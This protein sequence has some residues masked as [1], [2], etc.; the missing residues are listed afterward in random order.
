M[1]WFWGRDNWSGRPKT[2]SGS[3]Y[4]SLPN[5]PITVHE[6][7]RGAIEANSISEYLVD[8]ATAMPQVNLLY[9]QESLAMD[10][11]HIDSIYSTYSLLH[12]L[13]VPIGFV[14]TALPIDT[15]VPLLIAGSSY[16]PEVAQLALREAVREGAKIFSAGNRTL[17]F[18]FDERGV[19][20]KDASRAWAMAL[21]H[22]PIDTVADEAA[23]KQFDLALSGS[24]DRPVRCVV[25]SATA[26]AG[27]ARREESHTTLFGTVCRYVASTRTLFVMNLLNT[28]VAVDLDLSKGKLAALTDMLTGEEVELPLYL[29]P[30]Q[31]GLYGPISPA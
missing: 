26:T 17:L 24:L 21:P 22:L 5:Q 2:R 20:S 25:P 6:Y 27:V 28:T 29:Q 1:I 14:S 4:A 10:P 15:S 3:F 31:L 19:P 8:M 11:T 7:A 30:L 9:S 23:F 13:G 18:A 12:S 16:V